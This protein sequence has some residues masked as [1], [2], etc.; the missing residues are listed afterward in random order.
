MPTL[1][2]HH[3]IRKHATLSKGEQMDTRIAQRYDAKFCLIKILLC[4][5][6]CLS[7]PYYRLHLSI[8]LFL[9]DTSLLIGK[10]MDVLPFY[11]A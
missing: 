1:K 2:A 8:A 11:V 7:L 4:R 6:L 5:I 10:G 3:I 9:T